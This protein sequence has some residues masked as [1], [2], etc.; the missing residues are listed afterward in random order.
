MEIDWNAVSDSYTQDD[1]VINEDATI[2][3]AYTLQQGKRIY[4]KNMIENSWMVEEGLDSFIQYFVIPAFV[5]QTVPEE[6]FELAQL[7]HECYYGSLSELMSPAWENECSESFIYDD[8]LSVLTRFLIDFVQKPQM[9][10]ALAYDEK[11]FQHISEK[12]WLKYMKESGIMCEF[13]LMRKV[14]GI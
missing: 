12:K 13:D 4:F 5:D 6:F 3:I 9:N 8:V 10:K 7:N 2:N 1:I 11:T 14:Y